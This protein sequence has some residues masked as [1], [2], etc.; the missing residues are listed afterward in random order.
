LRVQVEATEGV[1][2]VD[3]PTTVVEKLAEATSLNIGGELAVAVSTNAIR[4]DVRTSASTSEKGD[5]M[6]RRESTSLKHEG[7]AVIHP[8]NTG[9]DIDK[10]MI[11]A[12]R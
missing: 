12:M 11:C 1:R 9:D 6:V 8:V 10:G 3:E 2:V 4:I 5:M 7:E